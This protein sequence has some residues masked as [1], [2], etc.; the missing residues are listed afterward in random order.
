MSETSAT[1]TGNYFVSNYPPF[2]FWSPEATS[3]VDRVLAQGAAEDVPLGLY[4]HLP[5]CRKR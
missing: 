1:T 5:F 4:V 2:S 3:E